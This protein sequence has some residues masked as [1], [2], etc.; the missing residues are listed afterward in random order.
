MVGA[1]EVIGDD[2]RVG[3]R[4]V[5]CRCL[6]Q[7]QGSAA[8]GEGAG[9]LVQRGVAGHGVAAGQFQLLAHAEVAVGAGADDAPLVGA[10]TRGGQQQAGQQGGGLS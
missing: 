9:A 6:G 7:P 10:S 1:W 5:R 2:E 8:G 4:Q 3:A